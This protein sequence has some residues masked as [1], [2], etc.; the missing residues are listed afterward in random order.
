VREVHAVVLAGGSAFGLAAADGVM[1]YLA[2][3]E[4]GFPTAPQS[5]G[6]SP[7]S[8]GTSRRRVPIVPAAVLFDLDLGDPYAY[9]GPDAGY[10]ACLAAT[11]DPVPQGNFGAGV[12]CS[13]GKLRGPAN[14]TKAGI[15]GACMEVGG[16]LK[17]GALIAVNALGDVLDERGGI[18]AGTRDPR[19]GWADSLALLR[20]DRTA[21][22]ADSPP[23]GDLRPAATVIGVVA[24]NALLDKEQANHV[25]L[26]AQDG[27]ARA[28]R[29]A[30]TQ[31]DGDTLFVLATGAIK[32]DVTTVGAHA[33]EAV[34]S[35]IRAGV[36]FAATAGGL[37]CA[38]EWSEWSS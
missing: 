5:D 23:D 31:W 9:P 7:Q 4:V 21:T 26:M 32:A 34:S 22:L 19:G 2:E 36:R 1:R 17:I 18:L 27:L 20:P 3:R 29:P 15:G 37:P 35:A 12:G 25:A 33:A 13:V 38:S 30:H 28:V 6:T 10:A 8:D 14:A 16:G 24:T 11:S